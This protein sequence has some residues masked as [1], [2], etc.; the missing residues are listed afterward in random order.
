MKS[1]PGNQPTKLS[2]LILQGQYSLGN[3]E[4]SA[5][6]RTAVI[7]QESNIINSMISPE[8]L[9]KSGVSPFMGVR[10]N[11]NRSTGF[12]PSRSFTQ[13]E[14]L[15]KEKN[16]ILIPKL[17]PTNVCTDKT[18]R[19]ALSTYFY[20]KH[21]SSSGKLPITTSI[22]KLCFISYPTLRT[23][24]IE[25]EKIGAAKITWKQYGEKKVP[26]AIF[27]CSWT[28]LAKLFLLPRRV[29]FYYLPNDKNIEHRLIFLIGKESI[30]AQ[31]NAIRVK[32]S[33]TLIFSK[34][35]N[36]G[37]YNGL[38]LDF[39]HSQ[40]SAFVNCNINPMATLSRQTL[41]FR[42]GCKHRTAGGYY[43][44][45][46]AGKG[47]LI[48][49]PGEIITSQVRARTSLLTLDKRIKWNENTQQTFLRTP[50]KITFLPHV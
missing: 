44:K 41:A 13:C 17:I 40:Y 32:K 8:T 22:A 16:K 38:K 11:N 48:D 15:S 24:I 45:L 42:A 19:K 29:K 6:I 10:V 34:T 14:G 7:N 36:E 4:V 12:R 28:E 1:T 47:W 33:K 35:T 9:D 18:V 25:L 46:F 43:V 2:N 3:P 21:I 27:L 37:L 39:T 31:N 30:K 20:L 5:I 23:R 49:E 26:E 50:N